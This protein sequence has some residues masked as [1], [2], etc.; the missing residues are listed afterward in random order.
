MYVQDGVQRIQIFDS[1]ECIPVYDDTIE[2]NLKYVIRFFQSNA[3]GD[4]E[5]ETLYKIE[6]YSANTTTYFDSTPGFNTAI[7]TDE[8][9]NFY[10]Q[11]PVTVFSLNTDETGI[12]EPI[13][14][15]QDSV[16]ETLSLNLDALSDWSDAYLVLQ[17]M[18]ADEETLKDMKK[19]RCILLDGDEHCN[20]EFLTKNASDTQSKDLLETLNTKIWTICQCPDFSD[21]QTF[22]NASSGVALRYKLLSFQQALGNIENQMRKA[23]QR[24]IELMSSLINSINGEEVWRDIEIVFNENFPVQYD[25]ITKL[26]NALRGIVSMQTMLSWIPGIDDPI[27]E[28]KRLEQERKQNADLY[29][30]DNQQ[31]FTDDNID[32]GE[33]EE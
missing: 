29:Y 2:Q 30:F 6:L 1:R 15:L 18:S 16:N 7:E 25:D 19:H 21:P 10:D 20:A 14:S 4:L 17:G 8:I 13:L 24:M 23:L 32:D 31:Q 28:M 33:E 27:E 3:G 11:C 5:T 12:F 26:V 22:G 9:P